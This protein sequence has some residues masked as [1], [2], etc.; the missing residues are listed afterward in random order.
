[1]S[2]HSEEEIEEWFAAEKQ[3]LETEFLNRINKNKEH[4]P[5]Y[6]EKYNAEMK[7]LLAKYEVESLKLIEANKKKGSLE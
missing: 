6:R 1:M 7:R 3:R 5:K 4:I 2:F